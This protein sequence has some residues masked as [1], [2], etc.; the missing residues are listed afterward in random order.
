MNWAP[1]PPRQDSHDVSDFDFWCVMRWVEALT[2]KNNIQSKQIVSTVIFPYSSTVSEHETLL[3]IEEWGGRWSLKVWKKI[4]Q[5]LFNDS[6]RR[7]LVEIFLSE[8]LKKE[9]PQL[10]LLNSRDESSLSLSIF[11]WV[12]WCNHVNF[13]SMQSLIKKLKCHFP[14]RKKNVVSSWKIKPRL[15]NEEREETSTRPALAYQNNDTKF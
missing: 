3:E 2:E 13:E 12:V 6:R 1:S 4:Q 5:S 10:F 14:S 8:W 11:W 15:R 9:L 7:R